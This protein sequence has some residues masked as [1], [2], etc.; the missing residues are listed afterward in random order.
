MGVSLRGL[1]LPAAGLA[2]AFVPYTGTACSLK[3]AFHALC[4]F[5]STGRPLAGSPVGTLRCARIHVLHALPGDGG[6]CLLA[7]QQAALCRGPPE[8]GSAAGT[9]SQAALQSVLPCLGWRQLP[10]APT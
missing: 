10:S 7:E 6:P 1:A 8:S 9:Q 2:S 5:T 4:W 3:M